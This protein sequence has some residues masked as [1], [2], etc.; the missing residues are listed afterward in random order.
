M[1][2]LTREV[3]FNSA[4][5]LYNPDWSEEKNREVFGPCANPNGHGHNFNL[6]VTIKGAPD[7][8]TGFLM[9]TQQLGEILD[10]QVVKQVDHKNL[11]KDVPFM[12]GI[13][14][15]MENFVKAIWDQ[16]APHIEGAELHRV[17]LW[18]THER[19]VDYYGE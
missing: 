19:Y 16:L 1:I 15:T 17:R 5:R 13:I 9:N 6:Y 3:H 8:D 12:E 18:E 14:P 11:N 7:P 4:H 2:Y 10:E